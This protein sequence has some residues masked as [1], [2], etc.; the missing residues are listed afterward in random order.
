MSASSKQGFTII[1]VLVVLAIAGLLLVIIFLAVPSLRRNSRNYQR[2]HAVE[3][4]AA[5]LEE[6]KNNNGVYPFSTGA[7][8]SFMATLGSLPDVYQVTFRGISSPHDYNP[9]YD[10]I[11]YQQA[12]WCNRYGDGENDTD[13]I[14]GTDDQEGFYAVWTKLERGFTSSAV[15]CVDNYGRSQ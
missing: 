10:Q 7:A 5:T 15:Y 3:T 4:V 1:E 9:P 14:A 13:P 11:V 2:Q 6:Y 8:S 12:H